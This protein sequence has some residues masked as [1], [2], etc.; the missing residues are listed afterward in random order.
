MYRILAVAL[1]CFLQAEGRHPEITLR[2][3]NNGNFLDNDKWLSTVSQYDKDKY[4][5]KFRDD[6]YF[7]N[8]NPNKPF[9]QA[10]DPS[11][12]PCLKVKCS[13]HK[14]CVTHDYET[15]TCVSRKQLVHSLRQ[16]K[17]NLPQRHWAGSSNLV[18]CKPCPLTHASS[19]CGSDG[20][21]YTTKCKLEFHACTSGKNIVARCEGPCPCLPGQES[22]KHRTE[23]AAQRS[24]LRLQKTLPPFCSHTRGLLNG[25]HPSRVTFRPN[26][27][28]T[29]GGNSAGEERSLSVR[30]QRCDP[31][32]EL[33]AEMEEFNS[34]LDYQATLEKIFDAN[35]QIIF[36]TETKDV[37]P[38]GQADV[39]NP[40]DFLTDKKSTKKNK[41]T[42]KRIIH[43]LI[44]NPFKFW[45]ILSDCN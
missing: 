17:G 9:D 16:K 14:V 5:N 31:E 18:K 8:W 19:V 33:E 36:S 40:I 25:S 42:L 12:D 3:S 43:H 27:R 7:R 22:P 30:L 34:H 28:S 29:S 15:A 37:T 23:K 21:T 2:S 45:M 13:P 10:L 39:Q 11:K 24:L 32:L 4:W 6:D 38:E 20:H 44:Y 26:Q 41:I 35:E 1:W